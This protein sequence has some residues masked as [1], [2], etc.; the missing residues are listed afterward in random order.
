M[1]SHNIVAYAM[2]F[3]SFLVQ[4]LS[5]KSLSSVKSII[6]FGSGARG[7][8]QKKS[9][10][11]IF[12][13]AENNPEELEQEVERHSERFYD[14]IKYKEYWK[15]LGLRHIFS[16]KIGNPNTWKSL[17]P[18]F[19]TD[20]IVLYGK[21]FS[22]NAQGQG[23]TLFFWEN[24]PSGNVRVNLYRALSGYKARGKKYPGMLTE[25]QGQRIGK[26]GILV[27]LE[28]RQVFQSLFQ[29]LRVP[30]RE[31]PMIAL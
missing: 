30:A 8:A 24:L 1:K 3:S 18:A 20:G 27:P 2:D 9:D 26:G 16:C 25:Y 6:L 10:I 5:S 4:R 22:T 15:L 31:I 13:E 12:I 19:V 28:H 7:E 21:Y 11:D 23:R 17:Y 14:S 29:S